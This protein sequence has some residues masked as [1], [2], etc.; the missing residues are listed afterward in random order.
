M[1]SQECFYLT[2]QN[3]ITFAGRIQECANPVRLLIQ[4]CMKDFLN[5]L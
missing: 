1:R 4:R 2:T 3:V 5:R